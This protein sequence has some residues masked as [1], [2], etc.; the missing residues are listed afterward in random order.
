VENSEVLGQWSESARYWEKHRAAIDRMF[1]PVAA[2]LVQDAGIGPGQTVLDVATGPGEPALSIAAIVGAGGE[3]SGVD[4]VPAMID[5]ARREA[6]RRALGNTAFR[7]APADELPFDADSFDAVVSRFGVMFFPSPLRGIREM[8]RVLKPGG[9]LA[10][11]VWNHA[12]DNPFHCVLADIVA[13][14]VESAP[15]D[16]DAPD[17]FRFA[18]PGKL[19]GVAREAG[20]ADARE[21]L[22]KFSI[23]APLSL[24]G[25]WEVRSEISDK[26]RTKLAQLTKAQVAEIKRSF[27]EAARAYEDAGGVSL[28]AEVLV[29]SGRKVGRR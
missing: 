5:A 14:Y 29:V 27:L 22:L 23:A 16:P 19:L 11:A 15:P 4:V 6:A 20:V 12:R 28:P 13:R 21:R 24:E 25:F 8:L 18:P 9:R 3:V 10:M 7:V 2:A 17:A 26:L 1:A